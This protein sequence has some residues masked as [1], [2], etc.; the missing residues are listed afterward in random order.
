M[1]KAEASEVLGVQPGAAADAVRA[2]FKRKAKRLHPDARP[3][4]PLADAGFIR[5][6][7]ACDILTGKVPEDAVPGARSPKQGADIG[8]A[9]TITLEQAASGGEV[10]PEAGSGGACATCS[11]SGRV[12]TGRH[13]ICAV[14][15]GDG[16][17]V[18]SHGLLRLRAMC[19]TCKGDGSVVLDTCQACG[20][21]GQRCPDGG[22]A[23]TV[24][25]GVADGDV[26]AFPGRGRP[27]AD[28]GKAG[29][30]LVTVRVARHPRFARRG[31]DLLADLPVPF[32]DLCLGGR[33]RAETLDGRQ[34]C[35]RIPAGTQPGKVLALAGLG[36]PCAGGHGRLLLRVGVEVPRELSAEQAGLLA[37]FRQIGMA[38]AR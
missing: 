5:I 1:D 22:G 8:T 16:V 23:V 25:P 19:G 37:R 35:V 33:V 28:G 12:G 27:G 20:G 38:P 11:G 32:A 6:K 34:A 9:V 21:S 17:I 2:A 24:P 3:G 31:D 13:A 7:K 30:L 29:T 10:A 15:G 18:K 4:D 26:L 36:M 14:C